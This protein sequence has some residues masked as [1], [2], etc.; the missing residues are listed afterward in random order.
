MNVTHDVTRDVRR[1]FARTFGRLSLPIPTYE[2]QSPS[3]LLHPA[4][5]WLGELIEARFEDIA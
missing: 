1:Y 2:K 5:G 3:T 4:I